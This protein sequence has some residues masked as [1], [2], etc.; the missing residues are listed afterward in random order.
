MSEPFK[1]SIIIIGAGP[2]GLL[3]THL[4]TT[5][6]LS[7]IK[8]LLLDSAPSLSTAPRATHYGPS[9][10]TVLRRAGLVPKMLELGFEPDRV[11]W[12][13][14]S[15]E[16]I[17]G[18]GF[19]KEGAGTEKIVCLPLNKL[20]GI[21]MG[22]LAPAVEKGLAKIEWGRNVVKVGEVEGEGRAWVDVEVPAGGESE[23]GE[24]KVER[25]Y[26]DYV[27]GCDGANSIVRRSLFG[28]GDEGFPGKTWDEQ[29]VATNVPS[30]FPLIP[31]T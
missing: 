9:A 3:L 2:S 27:V 8:V 31:T 28:K 15:G 10:M 24:K 18:L 26:A 25:L 30:P 21:M 17:A 16:K 7:P 29:I 4:L 5:L 11:C 1:P 22:E 23:E 14:L 19:G 6:P 12:R 13:K 20:G